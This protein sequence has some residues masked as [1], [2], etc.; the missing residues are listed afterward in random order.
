VAINGRKGA[1]APLEL[2]DTSYVLTV[3]YHKMHEHKLI[4]TVLTRH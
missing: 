4:F 3:Q 2:G 1:A